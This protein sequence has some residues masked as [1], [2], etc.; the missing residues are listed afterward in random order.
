MWPFKK[1]VP[2]YSVE[3]QRLWESLSIGLR[4][5]PAQNGC[6]V[7]HDTGLYVRA[8]LGTVTVMKNGQ[9]GNLRTTLTRDDHRRLYQLV[10]DIVSKACKEK[11][12]QKADRDLAT[13]REAAAKL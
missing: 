12:V 2:V 10:A 1:R 9:I 3:G 7:N 8:E 11:W 4:W 5:E 6:Q 13:F